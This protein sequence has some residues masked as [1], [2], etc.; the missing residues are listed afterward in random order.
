M[1]KFVVRKGQRSP[2]AGCLIS[3]YRRPG[4]FRLSAGRTGACGRAVARSLDGQPRNRNARRKGERRGIRY[5][6][7]AIIVASALTASATGYLFARQ[8]TP[9][10][11]RP[12]MR[13]PHFNVYNRHGSKQKCT[14]RIRMA[15]KGLTTASSYTL[16][17]CTAYMH[18]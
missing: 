13:N 3:E 9:R 15:Y 18:R 6:R 1:L 14:Q 7:L 10:D 17:R 8:R 5:D 12:E 4:Y 16:A 11:D 2:V